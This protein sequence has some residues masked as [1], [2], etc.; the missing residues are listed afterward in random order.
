MARFR[1]NA[2]RYI[3]R[4]GKRHSSWIRAPS[5]A[6]LPEHMGSSRHRGAFI[7]ARCRGKNA[8][9]EMTAETATKMFLAQ[10][11][12]LEHAAAKIYRLLTQDAG[13][14]PAECL[15]ACLRAAAKFL[16]QFDK[17]EWKEIIQHASELLLQHAVLASS[18]S[19]DSAHTEQAPSAR[20][21]WWPWR[22]G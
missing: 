13:L 10:E 7:L 11:E 9:H 20:G 15:V 4:L 1:S 19:G 14:T 12:A 6:T 22:W 3:G 2:A 18:V 17:N 5:N 21:S 8:M 16:I